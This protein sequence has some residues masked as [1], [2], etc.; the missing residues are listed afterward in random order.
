MIDVSMATDEEVFQVMADPAIWDAISDDG[1]GEPTMDVVAQTSEWLRL[2]GRVG[3]K[4]I[5]VIMFHKYEDGEMIH[6]N[7]LPGFR[8]GC[9]P[10]FVS[11]ALRYSASPTYAEIPDN[12]PNIQEFAENQGFE[13]I[14][15]IE[16]IGQKNGEKYQLGLYKR[17]A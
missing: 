13:R 3:G 6:V 2:A 12:L 4:L 7:V 1:D 14:S 9:A 16:S 11:K 10:E 5:G 8:K 17:V 15:T